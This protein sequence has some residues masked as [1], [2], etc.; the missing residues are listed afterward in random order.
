M[1]SLLH[2]TNTV[3]GHVLD[4]LS[5]TGTAVLKET[6]QGPALMGLQVWGRPTIGT[7]LM[8]WVADRAREGTK[9]GAVGR[10]SSWGQ[11]G[12]FGRR[13]SPPVKIWGENTAG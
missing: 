5:D 7:H 13:R 1:C 12:P 2:S 9:A 6:L 4:A 3:P 8:V 11:G 10:S